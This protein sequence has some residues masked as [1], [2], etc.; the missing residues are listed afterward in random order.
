MGRS[1]GHPQVQ[2]PMELLATL[3]TSLHNFLPTTS[4]LHEA[5]ILA[6]KQLLDPLAQD[7]SRAQE[8]RRTENRRKRKRA[9]HNTE[10][11]VLQIREIFTDGFGPNQIWEQARRIIDAAAEET[12]QDLDQ[13][14]L[15]HSH[16]EDEQ[17]DPKTDGSDS[18]KM[19]HFDEE[20]F[21]VDSEHLQVEASDMD[22][23]LGQDADGYEDEDA[24]AD[25]ELTLEDIEADEDADAL[26]EDDAPAEIFEPDPNNLNDGFFSIDAFNQQS[27]FMEQKDARGEDDNPSDEDEVDWDADP[28]SMLVP[29]SRRADVNGD[30]AAESDEDEPG[31]T[32]GDPDAA[33]EDEVDEDAD[34][35]D[36]MPGLG[37]TNDIQY[38]DFFEP[39]PKKPSK[40][41]RMR[42][43]PKTQPAP[44]TSAENEEDVA[45]DIQRAMADVR[46]DLLDSDEEVSGDGD[47]M[48]DEDKPRQEKNMSTHEK[49][50]AAIAAEIRKLEAAAVAKRDWTLSGEARATDRPMNSL[51]EEDLVFER[52]GKPVPVVTAAVSEDIE[53][54]V[55]RRIIAR[56]FDEVVRRRPE[57]IG[58]A[59]ETRRGRVE[60]NDSQS[61]QGLADIYEQE[62]LAKSDPNYEST[63]DKKTKKAH[64]EIDRLWKEVSGQLDVLSNLHFKP[65]RAEVEI[66]S[67]EDK[68]TIRMED[69]RPGGVGGEENM[70]APQEIFRAGEGG[71]EDGVVVRR[72]GASTSKDEMSREEKLRR[73]RR[74]KERQKK[75]GLNKP[76]VQM[77]AD[78]KPGKR[79]MKDEK[80]DIISDLKK[81]N[82]RVIGKKG[83]LEDLNQKPEAQQW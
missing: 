9:Q 1:N 22:E 20:G 40:T 54:L 79:S 11:R 37:N 17:H 18:I 32:L 27:Q 5:A 38:A 30:E 10:R 46:R 44:R 7:I 59:N 34:M 6:A 4:N 82:V 14:H 61:K 13:V 47:G 77:G 29:Q 80:S 64:S 75:A 53:A 65:K 52:A 55:K 63:L 21:E 51:I 2:Q 56:E 28:L 49:Q 78:G 50:K 70:L 73:R 12:E 76:V 71:K 25:A 26:S 23:I 67:V 8:T 35:H 48:S 57:A 58:T 62:H 24:D 83:Q 81:G 45:N 74:E 16:V 69:A 43:L 15:Q 36:S 60:L 66:K 68:P 3:R 41:K 39:P 72:S 19:V 33:S 31:P 42:A